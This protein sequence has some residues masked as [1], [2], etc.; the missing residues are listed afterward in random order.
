MAAAIG[1]PSILAYHCLAIHVP[2]H[3]LKSWPSTRLHQTLSMRAFGRLTD[4]T[5]TSLRV[6]MAA[7]T[8]R[9]F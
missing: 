4:S 9:L 2:G 1:S 5:E 7:T 8:G 6:P 3:L